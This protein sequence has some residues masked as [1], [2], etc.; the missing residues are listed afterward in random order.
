MTNPIV[1]QPC[2][3]GHSIIDHWHFDWEGGRHTLNC[4]K[5]DCK[6]FVKAK[7]GVKK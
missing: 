3:C 7:K 2:E 5:C 6:K 4:W 1:E